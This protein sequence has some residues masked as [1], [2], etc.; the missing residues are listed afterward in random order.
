ML[1]ELPKLLP[2]TALWLGGPEVSYHAQDLIQTFPQLAG[3][4]IGEGEETYGEGM[5]FIAVKRAVDE[6]YLRHFVVKKVLERSGALS[7]KRD[8]QENARLWI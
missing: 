3:I 2:D 5:I 8:L 1:S 7:A 4:M 6:L